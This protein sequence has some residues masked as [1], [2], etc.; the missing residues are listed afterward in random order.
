MIWTFSDGTT[1]ELG[2]KVE[3][4]TILAQQLRAVLARP[5]VLVEIWP[6]PGGNVELNVNDAALL[7]AWLRAELRDRRHLPLTLKR[8]D[9]VPPLPRA[10]WSGTDDH[11]PDV[12]H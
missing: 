11:D 6:P 2:G 1:V 8:P 7:D 5:R 4:A 12:I 3:G 9:D 10:P